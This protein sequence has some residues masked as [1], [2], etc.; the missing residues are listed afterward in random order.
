MRPLPVSCQ[1]EVLFYFVWMR[2]SGFGSQKAW[3]LGAGKI[4]FSLRCGGTFSCP[5]IFEIKKA[6]L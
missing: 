4:D 2:C 5:L 3:A 6:V 1:N